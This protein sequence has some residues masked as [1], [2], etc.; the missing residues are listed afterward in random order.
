M[1]ARIFVNAVRLFAATSGWR[2]AA[3]ATEV[4]AEVPGFAEVN[5]VPGEC[6][7]KAAF[8][9]GKP[10]RARVFLSRAEFAVF[11]RPVSEF[12]VVSVE[13]S[14]TEET[15]AIDLACCPFIAQ[16]VQRIISR[17]VIEPE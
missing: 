4:C 5:G 16:D 6:G 8:G 10:V 1:L 3:V 15:C 12:A 13:F 14:V 11:T 9:F 17:K 7:A 2:G